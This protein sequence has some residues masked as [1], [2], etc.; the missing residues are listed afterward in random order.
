MSTV[1][2]QQLA[3]KIAGELSPRG[4]EMVLHYLKLEGSGQF[5]PDATN[6]WAALKTS[7]TYSELSWVLSDQEITEVELAVL[8][9]LRG[10]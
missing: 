4:L 3:D 10:R 1:Q 2:I 6:L 8:K 9:H 5:R 7:P